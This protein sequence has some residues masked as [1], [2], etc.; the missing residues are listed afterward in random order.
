MNLGFGSSTT[1]KRSPK[2]FRTW[3]LAFR[4]S[5]SCG[6]Q[7]H[8]SHICV[9][10]THFVR[11]VWLVGE[12]LNSF[13]F[14]RENFPFKEAVWHLQRNYIQINR[15]KNLITTHQERWTNKH[16][17]GE[18]SFVSRHLLTFRARLPTENKRRICYHHIRIVYPKYLYLVFATRIYITDIIR[19]REEVVWC[20]YIRL[21]N[22]EN[23]TI[24]F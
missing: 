20:Y 9:D 5:Q 4:A 13:F 1:I 17:L 19:I 6:P 18:F 15:E 16:T 2:Y 14:I 8:I 10:S 24:L 11:E 7:S 22:Y 23:V 3:K 12:F 21:L